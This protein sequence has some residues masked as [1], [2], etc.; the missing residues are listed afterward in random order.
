MS[1]AKNKINLADT[2][3]TDIRVRRSIAGGL[4]LEIPGEDNSVKASDL[5]NRISKFFPCNGDVR[6][7]HLTKMA[8][9]RLS[10]LD[11]SV[12]SLEVAA[13]VA[14]AGGCTPTDIKTG[15]IRQRTPQ[16]MGTIWIK[17]PAVATKKLATRNRLTV[18][19]TL[20]KVEILPPRPLQCYRCLDTGHVK[21]QCKSSIDRS[22]CCYSCGGNNHLARNF[23][24]PPKC[25][26]CSEAGRHRIGSSQCPS[27]TGNSSRTLETRTR[28]RNLKR[29]TEH[30]TAWPT[31]YMVTT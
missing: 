19:W 7:S 6:I 5:A 11:Y 2:G 8:E 1:K 16:S 10:G 24:L 29:K 30:K 12:T 15:A 26:H 20:A 21:T 25:P 18:G 4:I 27:A 9:V 3:I 14:E 28:Q 13:A 23:T 31:A 22:G 17:C